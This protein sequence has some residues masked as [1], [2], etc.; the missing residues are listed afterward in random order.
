VPVAHVESE[1]PASL[2]RVGVGLADLL[3]HDT[4]CRARLFVDGARLGFRCTCPMGDQLAFTHC[5]A[6]ALCC[7]DVEIPGDS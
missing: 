1:R 5:V 6:L 2:P 4:L 3:D 7:G